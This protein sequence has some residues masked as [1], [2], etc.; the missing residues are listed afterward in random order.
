MAS[1]EAPNSYKSSDNE[2]ERI[3]LFQNLFRIWLRS[4]MSGTGFT[5]MHKVCV[6]PVHIENNFTPDYQESQE[7]N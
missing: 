3:K 7:E 1:L 2:K 4:V 6:T 5:T